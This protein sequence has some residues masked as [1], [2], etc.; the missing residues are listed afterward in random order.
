MTDFHFVKNL[1]IFSMTSACFGKQR[2]QC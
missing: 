1:Q 2:T